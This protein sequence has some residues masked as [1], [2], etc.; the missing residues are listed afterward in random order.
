M[1]SDIHYGDESI[2]SNEEGDGICCRAAD[3][4]GYTRS[5]HSNLGN[6]FYTGEF[7]CG[8]SNSIWTNN[9][10]TNIELE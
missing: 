6:I 10:N 9:V 5:I 4:C 1:I 7:S 3:S 8:E 2:I